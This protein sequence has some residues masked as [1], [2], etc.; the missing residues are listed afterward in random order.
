MIFS[1]NRYT[2]SR[3]MSLTQLDQA[4]AVERSRS[5]QAS[6]EVDCRSIASFERVR[7][8]LSLQRSMQK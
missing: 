5:W 7:L 8:S 1:E 2:L 4:P 3:I 6:V